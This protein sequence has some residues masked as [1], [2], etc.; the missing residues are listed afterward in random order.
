[1]RVGA[2]RPLC[3]VAKLHADEIALRP[4]QFTVS[5]GAELIERQQELSRQRMETIES[6]L[7]A[8]A[9]KIQRGTPQH[10]PAGPAEKRGP[11]CDFFSGQFTSL[12]HKIIT[13]PRGQ[14]IFDDLGDLDNLSRVIT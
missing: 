4:D 13:S 12:N 2:R 7:S 1:M 11:A 10:G 14:A 3:S 9:G 8:P 6:Y 5:G